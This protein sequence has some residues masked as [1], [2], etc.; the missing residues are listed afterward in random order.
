MLDIHRANVAPIAAKL[1]SMELTRIQQR[2]RRGLLRVTARGRRVARAVRAQMDAHESSLA[3]GL[4]QS[5][6]AR[7]LGWLGALWAPQAEDPSLAR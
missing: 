6:R 5:E 4:S 7:L 3:A 2:G 1:S